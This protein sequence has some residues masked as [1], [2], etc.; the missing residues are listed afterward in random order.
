MESVYDIPPL[1]PPREITDNDSFTLS[2]H[3]YISSDHEQSPTNI[4][5]NEPDETIIEVQ[6]NQVVESVCDV[7]NG[8]YEV[9]EITTDYLNSQIENLQNQFSKLRSRLNKLRLCQI[10]N[11]VIFFL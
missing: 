1:P 3:S 11:Y 6:P 10:I 2:D 7:T 8:E 5:Y 9:Y 4:I